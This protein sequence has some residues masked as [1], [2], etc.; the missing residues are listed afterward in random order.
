VPSADEH[1]PAALDRAHAEELLVTEDQVLR[2]LG[3]S[4]P[5]FAKR[6]GGVSEKDAR[7]ASVK[8]LAEGDADV[9]IEAGR[10]DAFS[11]TARAR[12]VQEAS[13][14]A[15]KVEPFELRDP[16]AKLEREL[17]GRLIGSERLRLDQEK[18][19]PSGASALLHGLAETWSV[20]ESKE[21]LEERDV[22]LAKRLDE[23]RASVAGP[24]QA[25]S[26]IELEELDEAVDP[27]ER[28][29]QPAEYP[30]ASK[31]VVGLRMAIDT[32]GASARTQ[33]DPASW[34]RL[35]AGLQTYVGVERGVETEAA[36]RDVRA[37]L[38][39]AEK[40]L[41]AVARETLGKGSSAAKEREIAAAAREM[42][43][44]EKKCTGGEASRLRAL[45]PPRERGRICGALEVAA[46]EG[47]VTSYVA[48]HDDLV[49]ALWALAV[50]GE[51][52]EP[53][54]A[55]SEAHPFFGTEPDQEARWM[56]V[57]VAQPV[58]V[59]GAGLAL[60]ALLGP[61]AEVDREAFAARAKAWRMF[62]D[63]PVD[64]AL[65]HLQDQARP[66]AKP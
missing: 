34:G 47:Q 25:E 52:R 42:T 59:V 9:G 54:G 57:A 15:A 38:E 32:A 60:E 37:R 62:G 58:A 20:P 51:V 21:A 3:A 13:T 23:V 17:L 40:A 49:I 18:S 63:A 8:A 24:S 45:T 53:S 29:M 6:I 64:L 48:L 11:F 33:V 10:L 55:A 7:V 27:L 35:L 46:G 50:D 39:R 1:D 26:R 31:S 44:A 4:D 22:R 12:A 19:L 66:E 16:Q 41:R 14:L 56:R 61:G 28:E 43:L 30:K 36:R 65:A 5:R 2:T